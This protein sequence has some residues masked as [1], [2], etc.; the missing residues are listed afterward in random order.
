M[1]GCRNGL[2]SSDPS[3]RKGMI[4]INDPMSAAVITPWIPGS[5]SA[6]LLSMERMRPC[7]TGL[8]KMTAWIIRSKARSSTY[9]PRPRRKRMSSMRSI[10][11]PMSA[12]VARTGIISDHN[13]GV[14]VAQRAR[15]AQSCQSGGFRVAARRLSRELHR[16]P[17]GG[18]FPLDLVHVAG[19]TRAPTQL[20]LSLL[21]AQTGERHP[22]R[23]L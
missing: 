21:E 11:L 23:D 2:S 9:C 16:E 13:G 4:G 20:N 10:G 17:P 6:A 5:L 1:T 3:W 18:A 22:T 8:R 19:A 15:D 7:A 12:L 14:L